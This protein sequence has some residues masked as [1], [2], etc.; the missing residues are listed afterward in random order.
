MQLAKVPE[1]REREFFS[2]FSSKSMFTFEGIDIKSKE[3][4][5]GLNKLEKVMRETGF[6]EK[7]CIGYHFKGE[8]MNRLC[9][10]TGNN[11]YPDDLT[12]LVIPN[13]YNPMVKLELGARWFDDIVANNA[14]KQ[15]AENFGCEPDF[16][17]EDD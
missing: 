13:Y 16:D 10:L 17:T 8:V 11:A 6:T 3:G 2:E 7:D 12:F 15:N 14:I 5:Q 9:H 4:R 1:N